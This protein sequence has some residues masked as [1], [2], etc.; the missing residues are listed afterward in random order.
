[1]TNEQIITEIDFDGATDEVKQDVVNSIRQIVEM[2]ML[3]LMG[4][5]MTDEQSDTFQEI[6]DSGNDQAVWDWLR[7]TIVGVDVSE[8]YET[9]LQGYLAEFKAKQ[10][11]IDLGEE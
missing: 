8:L 7:E 10:P 9:T 4:D 3:G 2:R 6:V 11:R 1:M 5:M